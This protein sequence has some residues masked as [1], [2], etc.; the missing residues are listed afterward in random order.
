MEFT[1]LIKIKLIRNVECLLDVFSSKPEGPGVIIVSAHVLCYEST[2]VKV[3]FLKFFQI[4]LENLFNM[5]SKPFLIL[6]TSCVLKY[7]SGNLHHICKQMPFTNRYL[8]FQKSTLMYE[9]FPSMSYT[10]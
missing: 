1:E 6:I 8:D 3:S 10:D 7:L 4:S 5:I 2:S 9:T